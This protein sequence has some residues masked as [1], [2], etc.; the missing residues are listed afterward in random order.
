MSCYLLD[1][2][3]RVG[4]TAHVP[5]NCLETWSGFWWTEAPQGSEGLLG[6]RRRLSSLE[7][8][9]SQTV[10]GLEEQLELSD[11]RVEVLGGH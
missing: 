4:F 6:R 10:E 8:R 3:T 2:V 7:G 1:G 11:V 5:L 9:R